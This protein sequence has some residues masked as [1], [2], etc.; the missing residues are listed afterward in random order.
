MLSIEQYFVFLL[1]LL[2]LSGCS[3]ELSRTES[4]VFGTRIEILI[5]DKNKQLANR[6]SSEILQEFDR[7]HRTYHAWEPSELARLND[8]IA[9]KKSLAVSQ[10]MTLLLQRAKQF[11]QISHGLFDPGIGEAIRTWGFHSSTIEGSI[12]SEK[13]L[14]RLIAKNAHIDALVFQKDTISSSNEFVRIDL[15]GYLKGYALDRAKHIL[16]KLGSKNALINIGG[17]IMALGKKGDDAW[18]VGIQAPRKEHILGTLE[19]HHGESIGTTGDYQRFFIHNGQRY[20]H[21]IHPKTWKPVRHTQAISIL[22]PSDFKHPNEIGLWSDWVTKPL[23]LLD[24]QWQAAATELGVDF[25]LRVDKNGNIETT[26]KMA[27]RL[28]LTQ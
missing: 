7:L 2:I 20:S 21:I 1:S 3:N 12:P 19:L 25:V 9:Q 23:F 18:V 11:Y 26:P 22:I 6:A 14:E 17:N 8:A 4:F 27:E 13:T 5:W 16:E 15:G 10:E 24:D 28:T